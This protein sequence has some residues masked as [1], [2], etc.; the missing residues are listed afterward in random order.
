MKTLF[1]VGL[2][3]GLLAVPALGEGAEEEPQRMEDRPA[4]QGL[5]PVELLADRTVVGKDGLSIERNGYRYLFASEENRAR[6]RKEPERYEIQMDGYCPVVP[7]AK[8][9]PD[10]FTV[11]KGKTYIFARIQC[12]SVFL[13]HP[14]EYIKE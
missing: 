6:F 3:V 10:I 5:D 4:L 1:V 8:G 14:E 13:Q 7:G 2:I 12:L 11:Y 9:H